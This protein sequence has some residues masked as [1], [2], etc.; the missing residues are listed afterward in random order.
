VPRSSAFIFHRQQIDLDFLK[1]AIDRSYQ[2]FSGINS[3]DLGD[4]KLG[5]SI[6]DALNMTFPFFIPPLY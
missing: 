3:L 4:N 5:C 6:V 2:I 1:D